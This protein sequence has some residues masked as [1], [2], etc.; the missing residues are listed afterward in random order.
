MIF[1]VRNCYI[2]QGDYP[3]ALLH[4]W[5]EFDAEKGSENDR[6]GTLVLYS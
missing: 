4:L 1:K 6:P 3:E 2:T 5:D